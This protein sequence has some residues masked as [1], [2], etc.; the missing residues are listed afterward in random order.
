MIVAK[1]KE[2]SEITDMIRGYSNVLVAGCGT[3]VA[4][5]LTGGE[6]EAGILATRLQMAAGSDDA[7]F[8]ASAA[9]VERQCDREFLGLFRDH[10]EEADAVV[11]LACGAGIQF[12]AEMYPDTPVFPG[13]DTSF[14]GVAEG[15]GVWSERCR[16]CNQCYLG[17]TGGICP[18][19][20]CAKSLL[21]GPC[22]GPQNGKCETSPERDCAWVMIIERLERQSRLDILRDFVPARRNDLSTHPA[23][24]VRE[25]Y[26]K[27]FSAK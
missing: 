26:R 22:G 1:P 15:A 4:V 13:V 9:T 18:V 27:R 7:R 16:S 10:I 23:K 11:S 24:I 6:K 14:I 20:M 17:I 3:C 5:C 19:T 12:L 8:R 2:F 25:D 21:N